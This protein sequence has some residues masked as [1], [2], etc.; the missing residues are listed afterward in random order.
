M[1]N[2]AILY[3]NGQGVKRDLSEAYVWF[4]R[5]KKL[6]DPRAAQMISMAQ[7]KLKPKDLK[8]ADARIDQWQPSVKAAAASGHG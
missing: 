5:A 6:G 1:T 2:I 3:Y 8:L 4:A 7:D